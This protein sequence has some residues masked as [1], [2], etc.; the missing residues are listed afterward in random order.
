[1]SGNAG[2]AKTWFQAGTCAGVYQEK[3]SLEE[4]KGPSY[5]QLKKEGLTEPNVYY[6]WW[7]LYLVNLIILSIYSTHE[8]SV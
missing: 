1:M 2:S 7:F 8:T 5:K 3:K 4:S 6:V